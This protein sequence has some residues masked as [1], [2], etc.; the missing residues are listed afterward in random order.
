MR[1]INLGKLKEVDIRELWKHEQYDF[2]NWLSKDENIELLNETVGLTLTDIDKEVYVGSYRC[3][4]V[5]VDEATGIKI[6]IENQ[7]DKTDH[8]HL[9]KLITYASGLD[10]SVIIWIVKEAREEHKSAIEWLNN[11]M[12]KDISFFLLEIHAYRIGDSLPAPKFEVLEQPNDFVKSSSS[13][14]GEEMNQ[15]QSERLNFWTE[16]NHFITENGKPF[17][18]RKAST[19]H[20]Y[21]IAIGTSEAHINITL[22][23]KDSKIGL[24]LNIVDNKDLYD[25]LYV[26]KDE[27]ESKLGF[28][29]EWERLDNNKSSKVSY[30][31]YGLNFEDHSNYPDL[32][33]EIVDKVVMMRD[34]FKEYI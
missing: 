7:L 20:W 6:I 2:S 13:I 23:N 5:A 22:V 27:I 31:I 12:I 4:L 24:V 15:S 8:D 34:I 29:L 26:H 9:G 30:Y 21:Q 10:A 16:F 11:N 1:K 33:G 25:N 14:K 17:N 19:D 3:D 18:K 32:M 28:T